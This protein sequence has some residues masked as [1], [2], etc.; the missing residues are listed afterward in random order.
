MPEVAAIIHIG[1]GESV[2]LDAAREV[3]RRATGDAYWNVVAGRRET[4]GA[5]I[6]L[7]S[8]QLSDSEILADLHRTEEIAAEAAQLG[9]PSLIASIVGNLGALLQWADPARA[10]HLLDTALTIGTDVGADAIDSTFTG[11]LARVTTGLGRPLE[12]L[13]LLGTVI[14]RVV[15]AGATNELM[16]LLPAV[17][18]PLD[19]LGQHR[20][21][22]IVH[23]VLTQMLENT[24][25]LTAMLM[26]ANAEREL[27]SALG[28]DEFAT[29]T[30]IGRHL[31]LTEAAELV[32]STLQTRVEA[33]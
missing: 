13:M 21:A 6:R 28:D 23:G 32:L 27:R 16:N 18:S 11:D 17:I 29:A 3:R 20:D 33:G 24:R 9:N 5:F 12:A 31:T 25:I 26:P 30:S 1:R 4:I 2:A 8:G 14:R 10:L 22:T 15:R 7:T 19:Q